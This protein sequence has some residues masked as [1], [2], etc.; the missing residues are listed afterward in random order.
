[1]A[2]T[3]CEQGANLVRTG[4]EVANKSRE[5][6]SKHLVF[7]CICLAKC[8]SRFNLAL[9]SHS[10]SSFMAPSPSKKTNKAK[11]AK[12]KEKVH[13]TPSTAKQNTSK[14]TTSK[15]TTSKGTPAKGTLAKGN[16]GGSNKSRSARKSA[17]YY[18]K[19]VV[20]HFFIHYA[21]S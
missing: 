20:G 9:L 2:R 17:L 1:M 15:G 10:P 18:A 13:S 3:G 8:R 7:P 4:R 21:R 11:K 6:G 12:N 5:L 16:L 19:C 14:G